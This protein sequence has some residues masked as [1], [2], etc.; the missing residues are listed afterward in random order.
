MP[1]FTTDPA[2]THTTRRDR[3][4]E[5]HDLLAGGVEDPVYGD[6]GRERPGAAGFLSGWRSWNQ[7]LL[8]AAEGVAS[9]L[10]Q[11]PVQL[12]RPRNRDVPESPAPS[13]DQRSLRTIEVL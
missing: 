11:D 4:S 6:D 7:P 12:R 8:R 5:P 9:G 3:L 13:L 2:Y 10:R 1:M